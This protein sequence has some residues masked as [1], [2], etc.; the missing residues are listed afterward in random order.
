MIADYHH[1]AVCGT[2]AAYRKG[3]L[4][5]C[6]IVSIDVLVFDVNG[7]VSRGQFLHFDNEQ[8]ARERVH[9]SSTSAVHGRHV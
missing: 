4:H 6:N 2:I 5:T 8:Q 3:A 1:D 9:R 7:T